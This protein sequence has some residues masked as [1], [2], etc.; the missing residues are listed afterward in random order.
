MKAALMQLLQS[1]L[2]I[3]VSVWILLS[4]LLYLF[5]AKFVYYPLSD[6][7][8][9]PTAT[10]LAYESLTLT[11]PDQHT[12]HGWYVPHPEP[13]A[14]MLFLHGN[15]GNISHRLDKLWIYHQLGLSVFIIDY[16][17]YGQSS[18]KPSEQGTYLDAEAAWHY[19]IGER[20]IPAESIIV[21]GESLGAAVATW[22]TARYTA[23]ALILESAFTSI[24]DMGKYYYPY[25]PVRLLTRI[26]YPAIDYL[27]N[28][29][30]P[31]LIIHSAADEIV[32]FAHG[33][34]LYQAANDPKS[35]LEINGDHNSGFYLSGQLYTDGL[36]R[37]ISSWFTNNH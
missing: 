2:F 9:T 20:A 15:G 5:Q 36:D 37:F 33:Q 4:L 31:V 21:Y 28:T 24:E 29:Q 18:G 32:P 25:L 6:I 34:V 35:F 27:P 7:A 16:R 30:I 12:I 8:L 13:R 22:L 3:V 23:G 26:K 17:G 19:L 11:S 1:L 14:T 10:G